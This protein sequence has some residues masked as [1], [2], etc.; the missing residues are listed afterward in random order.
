VESFDVG[1][2]PLSVI[3]ATYPANV[4][5]VDT[6]GT[7]LEVLGTADLDGVDL[8][9]VETQELSRQMYAAFWPDAMEALGKVGFIPGIR[10]EHE[11]YFADT[12]FVRAPAD[13]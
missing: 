1:T 12:L 11:Q 2:V 10:W 3:Q 5:V 4:L 13:G 7:E 9:V 6:Q 8:I